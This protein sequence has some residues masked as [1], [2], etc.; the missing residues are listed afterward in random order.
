MFYFHVLMCVVLVGDHWCKKFA[1]CGENWIH[2]PF[3]IKTAD[4]TIP[5][6]SLSTSKSIGSVFEWKIL[7]DGFS[8]IIRLKFHIAVV[9]LYKLQPLWFYR[10]Q[11]F[12]FVLLQMAQERNW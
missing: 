3:H 9:I 5:L 6:C 11:Y 10:A 12:I 4:N 8:A 1:Q 2:A 7:R